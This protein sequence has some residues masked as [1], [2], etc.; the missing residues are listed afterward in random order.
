MGIFADLLSKAPFLLRQTIAGTA[1]LLVPRRISGLLP[2][3]AI[4]L[5]DL[6]WMGMALIPEPENALD[7]PDGLCGLTG[8]I[9][10]SQ[11]LEGYRRGMF[12]MSH[13]GPLKWWAP[14]NRMV[15]FFDQARIEKTTRKLLRTQRF[16][17]TID[18]AFPA[19]MEACA[20]PRS[21]GTP[22]TWLTPRV[23]AL[24]QK[25]HEQGH[26]HSIEVWDGGTLVGGVYGLAVGRGFFTE[27]QFHT[28]RD[29]S[30]VAFSVLNRHL[31]AWGFAFNDGK[32]PTRYLSDGGM[33]PLG[34]DEFSSLTEFYSAEAGLVGR[35][36]VDDKL[37]DHCWEP[38]VAAGVTM[39]QVLADGLADYCIEDLLT[40]KRSCTW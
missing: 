32:H 33:K 11:L 14:R 35:W 34:R 3:A 5:R 8:D 1:Y 25:A 7:R 37:L 30:K 21:G 15:L 16:K 17:V 28:I 9:G 13:L 38:A 12:V 2:L 27:S 6:P 24:F 4:T 31:Q 22:L 10:V 29:A 40:T 36:S 26:A 18:R 19:V 20:A 23:Q 39:E